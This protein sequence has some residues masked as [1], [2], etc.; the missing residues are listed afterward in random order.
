LIF[1]L[2]QWFKGKNVVVLCQSRSLDSQL[3][4]KMYGIFADEVYL[5]RVRF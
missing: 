4:S 5:G 2:Q 3:I 1:G